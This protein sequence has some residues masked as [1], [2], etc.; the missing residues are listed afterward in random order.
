[1]DIGYGEAAREANVGCVRILLRKCVK[2]RTTNCTLDL[3]ETYSTKSLAIEIKVEKLEGLK[4]LTI[5][6]LIR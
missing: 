1:M 6:I 5:R 4:I 3:V 2:N